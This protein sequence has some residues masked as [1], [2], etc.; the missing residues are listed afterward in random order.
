MKYGVVILFLSN[1]PKGLLFWATIICWLKGILPS[2]RG[3][4]IKELAIIQERSFNESEK[5]FCSL[6]H[7]FMH[8]IILCLLTFSKLQGFLFLG[9]A[10]LPSNLLFITLE[11]C[12]GTKKERGNFSCFKVHL[13]FPKG[14]VPC[15]MQATFL[16]VM[17]SYY[18]FTRTV[19]TSFYIQSRTLC[20]SSM[21]AH[22]SLLETTIALFWSEPCVTP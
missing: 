13:Q 15:W 7:W 11:E 19:P 17:N 3:L 2:G 22:H 5:V 14:V 21:D 9:H 10:T 16:C 12:Q 18:M 8:Q 4:Q 1:G 6:L 20:H